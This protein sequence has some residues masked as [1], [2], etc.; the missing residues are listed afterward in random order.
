MEN[1]ERAYYPSDAAREREIVESYTYP[2]HSQTYDA[3]EADIAV[4]Y[5]Y[6]GQPTTTEYIRKGWI[7]LMKNQD[8][9][10]Y[11]QSKA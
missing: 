8:Y 6:F 9:W 10:E 11:D 5:V 1:V 2:H 4:L 3:Y 7:K